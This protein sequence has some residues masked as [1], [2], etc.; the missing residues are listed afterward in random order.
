MLVLYKLSDRESAAGTIKLLFAMPVPPHCRQV[1]ALA[2]PVVE[3]C[4][5]GQK[6]CYTI[7]MEHYEIIVLG[8]GGVG[9]AVLDQLA[10]RGVRAVGIDRFRPPHDPGG[11]RGDLRVE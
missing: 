6:G 2:P 1:D 5:R 10:Q 11:C 7:I 4:P 8:I 9:S 3:R